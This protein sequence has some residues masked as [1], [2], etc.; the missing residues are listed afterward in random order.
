M[1]IAASIRALCIFALLVFS[2]PFL[3]AQ[4]GT[5]APPPNLIADGVPPVPTALA[6]A[7]ERYTDFRSTLIV[8]WHSDKRAMLVEKSMSISMIESPNADSTSFAFLPPG[9]YEAYHHPRAKSFVL[10]RDADGD[11]FY[12]LYSVSVSPREVTL[13]TDGKSRNV[14]PVWSNAGDRIVYGSNRRNSK[15]IDLYIADVL[16]PQSTRLLAQ[17]DGRYLQAFDWSPDDGKIL[18]SEWVSNS[19][20]N[21]WLLDVKTGEKTR[22]TGKQGDA[23]AT[24]N[25]AQFSKD[26][27]GLYLTT[28]KDAEWHRLAYMDLATGRFTLFSDH[29]RWNIDEFR[30]SPDGKILAFV[31]NEDGIGRLHLL[32]TRTGK[33]M[34]APLLPIGIASKLRWHSNGRDLGFQ[35][36]SARSPTDVYSLDAMTGKIE[37]WTTSSTGGVETDGL[38]DA[39]L[40]HWKSFDGKTISGFLHRPPARW[41]GKRPVIIAIHGGPEEQSRPELVGED[42]YLLNELGVAKIYPNVRGSSGYGKTFLH[43]DDGSQREAP[44]KDVGALID[45][46]KTQPDLDAERIMVT[47]ESYG[48]YVA[49]SVSS[50]YSDRIRGAISDVG[51][52]NLV[53]FLENTEEWR[54]DIRRAEYGDERDPQMREFLNRIAPLTNA[55]RIRKPL[56]IVQGANDPRVRMSEAE[57]LVSKVRK[58]GVPVWYLLAKDEG[59]GFVKA[60][61]QEYQFYSTVLFIQSFLLEQPGRRS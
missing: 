51:P 11:E 25:F 57:Q 38:R 52:S 40:I 29:I 55:G 7:A 49:L 3:V 31:A 41:K 9:S 53:T 23:S 61:N 30:L 44:I 18:F 27:K 6:G 5:L 45:W 59:H 16:D 12:Q 56:M 8:G 58:N 46:I 24:Y 47:G 39:E 60:R 50:A 10:S 34:P 32:D 35:F 21:L 20:N 19:E 36:V 43:S 1:L 17:L 26:G 54:R 14:E 33:E 2:A 48:G 15:D 22:L 28:D 13:L 4:N 42:V 37:R